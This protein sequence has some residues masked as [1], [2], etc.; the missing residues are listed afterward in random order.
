MNSRRHTE[1]Q[2][3]LGDHNEPQEAS[4]GAEGAP[5]KRAPQAPDGFTCCALRAHLQQK[6]GSNRNASIQE[7]GN[8]K[9]CSS[10]ASSRAKHGLMFQ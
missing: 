8:D 1:P 6:Y 4:R 3:A 9:H 7:Y 2:E 10:P 5:L